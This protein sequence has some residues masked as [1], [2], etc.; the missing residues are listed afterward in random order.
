VSIFEFLKSVSE[1]HAGATYGFLV[2]FTI[3][4]SP[5]VQKLVGRLALRWAIRTENIVD[6]L[7]V[8]AL[9]PFRFVFT[10]PVALAFFFAHWAEPFVYEARLISG[11]LLIL[12]VVDTAIKILSAVAAVIR[13]RSGDK[14][15][16]S[17]GYI[18]L[19]KILAIVIGVAFAAAISIDTDIV[20]LVGGL[21]AATAVLGFIFKDTL[22]AIFASM[23][24]AS[25]GLIRE[26][27]WLIVPNYGADGLVEHIGL[28]D[29]KIVNWDL[30]TSLVPTHQ[31]LEVANTNYRHV[32]KEAR[33]RRIQ[34]NLLIDLE[35]IRTCDRELLERLQKVELVA[36]LASENL[37]RLSG[38]DDPENDPN[39][40]AAVLTN[41]EIFR[42]YIDRYLRSRDDIHQKQN[43]IL[44]R[45]LAPDRHGIPIDIFAFTR[46]TD[47]IGFS[48]IQTSVL[49]HLIGVIRVFDLKFFQIYDD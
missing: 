48:N 33:A 1:Q 16:S 17:T 2:V 11:L 19:M 30:T 4:I 47:L 24:I 8:D 42:I 43:F 29:I 15:A 12:V 6:D 44:V 21:G 23:K 20:T 45:A 25:W 38:F 9:R 26:G 18:D 49:S 28:Y 34:D 35:T 41:F 14:G 5:F 31:V 27:D 7:V 32:Q 46:E 13:H 22:H 40:A 39:C 37:E 10:L 36:D 3:L